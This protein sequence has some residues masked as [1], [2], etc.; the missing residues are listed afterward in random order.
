MKTLTIALGDPDHAALLNLADQVGISP[1]SLVVSGTIGLLRTWDRILGELQPASPEAT[2]VSTEVVPAPSAG[3]KTRSETIHAWGE[4]GNPA[5][6][7]A[8]IQA[9]GDRSP[10]LRR[11]AASA[12]GKLKAT[13]AVEPLLAVVQGDDA[14]QARQYALKALGILRDPRAIDVLR[15][16][17]DD[18]E[19]KAYNHV[20]A[21]SALEACV[22]RL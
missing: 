19:E 10:N 11:L 15:R 17:L 6:V 13:D 22:R 18:K 2:A 7:P 1:E 4:S 16:V 3:A 5:H 14:P 20:A 9:L 8:L 21:K 12:L